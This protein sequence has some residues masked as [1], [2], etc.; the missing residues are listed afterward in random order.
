M[1]PDADRCLAEGCSLLAVSQMYCLSHYNGRN[2]K[3]PVPRNLCR[4][5]GCPKWKAREGGLCYRHWQGKNPLGVTPQPKWTCIA[6]DCSET[7]NAIGEFLCKR[8]KQELQAVCQIDGCSLNARRYCGSY[9]H[10]HWRDNNPCN[11]KLPFECKEDG[12]SKARKYDGCESYCTFHWKLHSSDPK[13]I[14]KQDE[15]TKSYWMS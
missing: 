11:P 15:C 1:Y 9:C 4:I 2:L 8:H 13:L 3:N 7:V 12:C 10:K 6:E 5:E 14:P